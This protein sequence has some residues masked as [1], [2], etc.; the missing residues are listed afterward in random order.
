MNKECK[1][2]GEYFEKCGC[3]Q[4]V[5][6]YIVDLELLEVDA[7][8]LYDGKCV[9]A[10][11]LNIPTDLVEKIIKLPHDDQMKHFDY[12]GNQFSDEEVSIY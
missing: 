4:W 11:C 1:K 5:L 6:K 12:W 9:Q 8:V 7:Y 3:N 2:C 10:T